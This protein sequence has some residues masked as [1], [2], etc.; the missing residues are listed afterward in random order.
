VPACGAYFGEVVRR[1][2][3]E[4]VWQCPEEDYK[5]WRLELPSASISFNP[6]GVAMEVAAAEDADGWGAAFSVPPPDRAAAR[7]AADVLGE[8]AEEVYYTFAVRFDVLVQVHSTLRRAR[9]NVSEP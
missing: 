4:G 8:V 5:S 2:L 6:I 9:A 3:G 7:D 1:H